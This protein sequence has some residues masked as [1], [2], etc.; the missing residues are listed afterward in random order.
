MYI[1]AIGHYIPKLR[2]DNDYF[3]EVSGLDSD[4][5]T[6][7]TGIY[8]RSKISENETTTSMAIESI[9]SILNDLPYNI[10][11]VDLI[12]SAG[13]T[14]TDT[15]GTDAHRVQR[16]Y[17]I[18]RAKVFAITSACSSFVN[19]VEIADTF[20]TANKASKALII[21]SESNSVYNDYSDPKSGHLWGDGAVAM[22]ISKDKQ[23]EDEAQII[24]I[25]TKGL[26]HIGK[27]P[28]GV[29]LYPNK[30][31]ISMHDGRDVF[32]YACKYMQNTL[33][34]L[35]ERNN[36]SIKDLKFLAAHQANLRIISHLSSELELSN[37]VVLNTIQELGNTGSAS[38]ILSIAVH[39]DKIQQGDLVG[40]TVFGGGYSAGAIIIKF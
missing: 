33:C 1:N 8:S 14:I 29:C 13:Y 20:F 17:D 22:F 24:D 31:G 27:G 21:C 38:A 34:E 4:W 40:V 12:I 5:I 36:Y 10:K 19:A 3:K 26:G 37:D 32:M 23:A 39:R 15:V 11:D 30:G 35:L 2:I 25:H 18:P 16:E 9:N 28:D 7:R 6:T